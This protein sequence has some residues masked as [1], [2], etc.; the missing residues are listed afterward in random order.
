MG[1]ARAIGGAAEIGRGY[2]AEG[3]QRVEA[4]AVATKRRR[5]MGMRTIMES[6]SCEERPNMAAD[7]RSRRTAV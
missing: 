6:S 1:D 7:S 3:G 5:D 4:A 2:A